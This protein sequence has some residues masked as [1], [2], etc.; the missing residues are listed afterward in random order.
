M[1]SRY[2]PTNSSLDPSAVIPK[3]V[4]AILGG[5]IRGHVFLEFSN[6]QPNKIN[7][8]S[9]IKNLLATHTVTPLASL[10]IASN[11]KIYSTWDNKHTG[12]L[13]AVIKVE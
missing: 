10:V 11:G 1:K 6:S 3:Y 9:S 7:Q 12:L 2:P 8:S 4:A 13:S 5:V